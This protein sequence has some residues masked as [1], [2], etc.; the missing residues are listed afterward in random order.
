M[1]TYIYKYDLAGGLYNNSTTYSQTYNT[2]DPSTSKLI[3]PVRPGYKFRWFTIIQSSTGDQ[4][5][6]N[7]A[8][9][10]NDVVATNL[11]LPGVW[12]NIFFI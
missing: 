8:A 12:D 10:H 1:A 2:A 3:T 9:G 4:L 7:A 5:G 6:Q 11:Q